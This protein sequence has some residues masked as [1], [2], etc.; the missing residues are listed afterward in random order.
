ML[1]YSPVSVWKTS[2]ARPSPTSPRRSRTSRCSSSTPAVPRAPVSRGGQHGW[3]D[4][5]RQWGRASRA[6][7]AAPSCGFVPVMTR[8]AI[9]FGLW[10][11][12]GVRAGQSWHRV[13]VLVLATAGGQD[14]YVEL[15]CMCAAR[16]QT[17][18]S[19]P[20]C[21]QYGDLADPRQLLRTGLPQPPRHGPTT[22]TYPDNVVEL[23]KNLNHLIKHQKVG[24][25]TASYESV[26]PP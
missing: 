7:C 22:D 9:V 18:R 21:C 23:H 2:R 14:V 16:P 25:F 15:A 1:T 19:S 26:K 10:A 8:V 24:P 12:A 5:D 13:L 3:N 17:R 11:S 4:L 6:Q 20:Q